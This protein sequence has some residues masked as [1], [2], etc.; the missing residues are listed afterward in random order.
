MQGR[1]FGELF[2]DIASSF[3]YNYGVIKGLE[4]EYIEG[5]TSVELALKYGISHTTVCNHLRKVNVSIRP[6]RRQA[7]YDNPIRTKTIIESYQKGKPMIE[8]A[9]QENVNDKTINRVLQQNNITKH[10]RNIRAQTITMPSNLGILGYIAGMFDGE[11]NLQFRD[12][13]NKGLIGCK[14]TIYST[15]PELVEWFRKTMGGGKVRWDFARVKR[16]GWK[17]IGSW[18]LYRAQ[19]VATFLITLYPLLIIKKESA[20]KALELFSKRFCIKIPH[21]LR[22]S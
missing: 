15:T 5:A 13:H 20:G 8:I 9:K 3:T 14:I 2:L 6:A 18:C 10:I 11:G 12:K 7:L 4:K 21:Q 1:R 22:P 17:P 16:H 19:D